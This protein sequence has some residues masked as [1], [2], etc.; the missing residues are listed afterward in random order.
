LLS[1]EVRTVADNDYLALIEQGIEVWNRWR[2]ENPTVKPDFSR[3]YFFEADLSEAD[4]SEADF[5]RACLIGANLKGANLSGAN[6]TGAYANGANLQ[7]ANLTGADLRD[8]KFSEADL[9]HTDLTKVQAR[10]SDFTDTRWTGACLKD[11]QIDSAT[12]LHKVEA[13]Y[14]YLQNHQQER[15]PEQGEFSSAELTELLHSLPSISALEP[16]SEENLSIVIAL[17]GLQNTTSP[18]VVPTV[19]SRSSEQDVQHHLQPTL[20]NSTASA[21]SD[22]SLLLVKETTDITDIADPLPLLPWAKPIEEAEILL[23]SSRRH[24]SPLLMF[25]IGILIGLALG[26]YY[27]GLP[28]SVSPAPVQ[29][30]EAFPEPDF[31]LTNFLSQTS[32]TIWAVAV[33]PNGQTLVSGSYDSNIELWDLYSSEVL[34]SFSGHS[35]AI[36]AVAISPDNQTLV[37]GGGDGTI[38]IWNLQTGELRRTLVGHLSPV[39]TVAISSDGSKFVSG[40]DD[41]RTF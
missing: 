19:E 1:K 22:L 11:L 20:Q 4:L 32:D 18:T 21:T 28:L 16:E 7:G 31:S 2:K 3:A 41:R 8:A 6:L 24:R 26:A 35:D 29:P 30:Q 38:K 23:Q 17:P 9:T 40:E 25:G 39:W 27:Y 12:Q 14:V 10:G 37:S 33:S 13:E 36:R 34:R 15:R 5:S